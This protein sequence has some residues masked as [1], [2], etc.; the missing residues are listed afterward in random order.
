M[1]TIIIKALLGL[2]IWLFLPDLLIKKTKSKKRQKQFINIACMLV[3]ILILVFAGNRYQ[4]AIV[5]VYTSD[6]KDVSAEMLKSGMAWHYKQYSKDN[7]HAELENTAR[8]QKI[9]L[10]TDKNPVAPWKYRKSG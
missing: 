9:G 7:E 8:Q 1:T 2:F 3:G 4:R 5:R 6:G 10:W